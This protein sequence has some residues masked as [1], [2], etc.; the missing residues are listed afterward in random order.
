M[1]AVLE[2]AH[3]GARVTIDSTLERPAVVPLGSS[4]DLTQR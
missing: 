4:F 1:S 2:S 3:R